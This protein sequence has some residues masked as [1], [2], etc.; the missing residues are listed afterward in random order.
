M[1]YPRLP[2]RDLSRFVVPR[3]LT[4]DLTLAST[5]ALTSPLPRHW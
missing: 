4:R 1:R 3:V 5:L 2:F